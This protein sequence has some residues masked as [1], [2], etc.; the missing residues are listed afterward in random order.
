[1]VYRSVR[2]LPIACLAL[3][4]A[5]GAGAAPGGGAST[6]HSA[7]LMADGTV[8]TSG[9]NYN[10]E[11]GDGSN[12]PRYARVNVLS[13]ATSVDVGANHTVAL[14]GGTAMVWGHNGYGQNCDPL[15]VNGNYP[16]PRGVPVSGLV[17]VAATAA[18]TFLLHDSGIV[19][20]CGANYSGVL[21][22]GSTPLMRRSASPVANLTDA[23]AISGGVSH[24]LAL[25]ANGTVVGWGDNTFGQLG[26]GSTTTIRPT[27]VAVSGLTNVTAV[28]AGQDFSMALD[29]SGHVWIWG[30]GFYGIAGDG[31]TTNHSTPYQ[32][33]GL[34][35]VV[36]IA[37]GS[38]HAVALDVNHQVWTWGFGGLGHGSDSIV[39]VPTVLAGLTP[40]TAVTAGSNVTFAF[41][42]D[43][44]IYAWGDNGAGMLGDGTTQNRLSPTVLAD[45]GG[46]WR[47]GTPVFTPSGSPTYSSDQTVQITS[48]TAGAIVRYTTTGVDPIETDAI[49]PS[50]GLL[51]DQN[52]TVK[53]R[54]WKTGQGPSNVAT[55][56]Y[57]FQPTM[58]TISPG[59][60]TY[61]SP[62]TVT[63]ATPTPGATLR[64][65]TNGTEPTVSSPVYGGAIP[66]ST[67]TTLRAKAFKA[68]WNDSVPTTASYAFN[69]GTIDTPVISPGGGTYSTDQTVSITAPNAPN[70][71]VIRYTLT[72]GDPDA[73]S[74]SY[75][76]PFTVATGQTVKARVF[77]TD[78]TT[79]AAASATYAF[80]VAMPTLTVASGTYPAGQVVAIATSTPNATIRY[81]LTGVAPT[82]TD[83]VLL[84]GT[85][86]TL[87][88]YTLKATAFKTGYTSSTTATATYQVTGDVTQPRIAAG[89]THTLVVKRDGTVWSFGSNGL[90]YLGDGT[91]TPKSL[92][93]RVA[94]LTG[95]KGVAAGIQ[96]SLAVGL[97]GRVYSWGGNSANQL[98][99]SVPI[100]YRT[101][102]LPVPAVTNAVAV[103]AGSY[104]SLALTN[105]GQVWAWG[106]NTSGQLGL[107]SPSSTQP[108]PTLVP[109]LSG[110]VGIAAGDTHSFA[111]TSAG[112]LYAWGA[113]GNGKLGDNSQNQRNSP[114]VITG[115]TGVAEAAA[116]QYH[117]I[118]RTSSGQVWTWG[119]NVDGALGVGNTTERW[120]PT[121][122]TSLSGVRAVGIG[123]Y[124]SLASTASTTYAWGKNNNSQ[125]GDGLT[126]NRT[127]PYA[128]PFGPSVQLAGGSVHSV[129][130]DP[131]GGV[132]TWGGNGSG[133]LGNGSTT[134]QTTP[135]PISGGGQTWGVA[136]PKASP[137]PTAEPFHDTQSVTLQT[138]TSGATIRYTTNGVDPVGTDTIA[139]GPIPITQNTTLKAKA[140]KTGLDPSAVQTFSYTLQLLPPTITPASGSYSQQPTIEIQAQT[141]L[142]GLEIRYTLDG[143]DPGAASTLYG[144]SFALT[145][146]TTVKARAFKAGWVP[147]AVSTSLFDLQIDQIAPT[148]TAR[149]RPGVN[150]HGWTMGP[151]TVT[152]ICHDSDGPFSS[153]SPTL[154][155]CSPEELVP[156]DT[157][158]HPFTGTATDLAGNSA[159]VGGVVKVDATP[160]VLALTSPADGLEVSTS[161][162]TLTGTA[163]D[164]MSGLAAVRCNDVLATVSNGNVTCGVPLRAGRNPVIL[165]ASDFAGHSTSIGIIVWRTVAVDRLTLSPEQLTLREG[166]EVPLRLVNNMGR[167]QTGATWAVDDASVVEVVESPEP[168]LRA[169]GPGTATV[170]ASVGALTA[171]STVTVVG[172]TVVLAPGTTRWLVQATPGATLETVIYTHQTN[173]DV[174]EAVLVESSAGNG[175]QLRGV[176]DGVTTSLT[177]IA[178][179]LPEQTMGDSFGGVLLVQAGAGDQT[180]LQRVGFTPDVPAWR[181][182][183]NGS[184]S[185]VVQAHDGTIFATERTG[186]GNLTAAAV[187]VLD[188]SAGTLRARVPI[189]T[190][191][192]HEIVNANCVPGANG[193]AERIGLR[194]MSA[195]STADTYAVVTYDEDGYRDHLDSSECQ[196]SGITGSGYDHGTEHLLTVDRNGNATT[197][198]L[199]QYNFTYPSNQGESATPSV[200]ELAADARGNFVVTFANDQRQLFGASP[201][202]PALPLA[203]YVIVS[204]RGV[205]VAPDAGGLRGVDSTTGQLLWTDPRD[206]VP[207]AF[208]DDGVSVVALLGE[209]LVQIGPAAP[210]EETL[211]PA[212]QSS[213]Q[214]AM[215]NPGYLV[216]STGSRLASVLMPFAHEPYLSGTHGNYQRQGSRTRAPEYSS[217]DTAGISALRK[218]F[219]ISA[220]RWLE[221]GGSI[222]RLPNLAFLYSEAN[223]GTVE[224]V[225]VSLC[226]A[227][228]T[229]F[230][231]YHT[232][233]PCGYPGPSGGDAGILRAMNLENP[234]ARGYVGVPGTPNPTPY[235]VRYYWQNN[236]SFLSA[237]IATLEWPRGRVPCGNPA[238]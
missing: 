175:L 85:T 129:A 56:T 160:P 176:T 150:A 166:D 213:D 30:T 46:I 151:A 180:S 38:S 145:Q 187:V 103:A 232:H 11:V 1:M 16:A 73:F 75:A 37:A 177:P 120:V 168:T 163:S 182:V 143:T 18:S 115:I 26:D 2:T 81:S 17:G 22:D 93:V 170:T 100:G 142:S 49:V 196:G 125:V 224:N 43:G 165:Q 47:T 78:Y 33:P 53:A 91:T 15:A 9:F 24:V 149:V 205:Y 48:A 14:V 130:L 137:A 208:A 183:A 167:V 116:G 238:P 77:R 119:R 51:V 230:G 44:G 128:T 228:T 89:D 144:G 63:I 70:G 117:S 179:S 114:V 23:V 25:R 178:G 122:V 227:G 222:C 31:T 102:P 152:F 138:L 124:H 202:G 154:A 214:M 164:A 76:G 231:Q 74:P 59:T 101:M 87:G 62:R 236:E 105:T 34:V 104:Y 133:Q 83:P 215:I 155:S 40:I 206:A 27:P 107:G 55:A 126:A 106:A 36:Q 12:Q 50:G 90:G 193:V 139:A 13:G 28:S 217:I 161:F 210:T 108:T 173:P 35:D 113:N 97:D 198:L 121:Q 134:T 123:Q 132:W 199:S 69:Y 42:Q 86:L 88:D 220:E 29:T 131:T 188:G 197:E 65:T 171:Q 169:L 20:S 223:Q 52:R 201:V 147:S 194:N 195:F 200:N 136:P 109:G 84:P 237:V 189:T 221:Y 32:V 135:A 41:A 99:D 61:T 226:P 8:W 6:N 204:D 146:T 216:Y 64:Y 5:F 185:H 225:A 229:H 207:L 60:G 235:A 153:S 92:P 80:T 212:P 71:A 209:Q 111:W 82:G 127:S 7:L 190:T 68:G 110:I 203:A 186:T 219:P 57:S 174:P 10:G 67:Q 162:V 184:L 211:L 148:I 112:A 21:G 141:G 157:A 156:E 172:A 140:W 45:A 58:P 118:A 95:I 39:K 234:D 72:G 66:M 181:W 159:F 54:A 3:G 96:H 233:P 94:A 19:D 191:D 4:L 218:Y 79:S 98:G 158:G 192:R